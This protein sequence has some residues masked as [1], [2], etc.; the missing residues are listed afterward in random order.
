M[1]ASRRSKPIGLTYK[2]HQPIT[3]WDESINLKIRL[4]SIWA[5]INSEFQVNEGQQSR[6]FIHLVP[7]KEYDVSVW[8][9]TCGNG[10]IANLKSSLLS[11]KIVIPPESPAN[12]RFK[13]RDSSEIEICFKGPAE[14]YFTGF[15]FL[16]ENSAGETGYQY[17]QVN[18]EG[19]F[20]FFTFFRAQETFATKIMMTNA[21]P[22]WFVTY[23]LLIAAWEKYHSYLVVH[24]L[25]CSR[26]VQ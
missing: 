17:L 5:H 9:K 1:L 18:D 6:Q 12:A 14:G 11:D 10:Q 2:K 13:S 7:G 26:T 22:I 4:S 15:D 16:W 24:I 19:T 25:Y 3:C 8:G 23:D 21:G 20:H